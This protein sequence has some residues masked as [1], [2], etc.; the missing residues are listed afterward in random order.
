MIE[1]EAYEERVAVAAM[2]LFQRLRASEALADDGNKRATA[3]QR[4]IAD[5]MAEM[6]AKENGVKKDDVLVFMAV[7]MNRGTPEAEIRRRLGVAA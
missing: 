1:N 7:S 2:E 3:G 4:A 6:T 5:E